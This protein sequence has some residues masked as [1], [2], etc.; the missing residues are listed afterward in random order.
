MTWEQFGDIL[1]DSL[2]DSLIIFAFVFLFHVIL[3]FIETP[4]SNFLVKRKKVSPIFGSLFGLIPQCGTSVVAAELYVKRYITLGTII[5][6]FLSCSDEA[7]LTLISNWSEKS[8]A[9]FPL[10][11]LKLAT[12]ILIG[13]LVDLVIRH[14]H[15]DEVDHIEEEKECHT[16]HHEN[17]PAHA[18]LIHPLIHAIKVFVC[19]FV[20][21][22]A[23]GS[24][25]EAVGPEKFESFMLTNRYLTPLF[26]SIIG[27][28]PNCASSLLITEL[29]VKG[30][31]S[32]GALFA[33][34][35]VNSGLG[36]MVLLKERRSW[37]NTLFIIFFC[38]V[39]A[40]AL[41]YLTCL[42]NGF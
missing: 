32:F 25:I 3:S 5:A 23:L 39:V 36:V 33:G 35:L 18:H 17:T 29:Y 12:G 14:Q 13:M 40:I 4:V 2:K 38:F 15:V 24:I 16:H 37:K 34:L 20:I 30:S 27:L 9:I 41:G 10:I 21:N 1:L 19:V 6:V 31:L 42:V 22:V 26:S 11:G 28:I 8:L 7:L